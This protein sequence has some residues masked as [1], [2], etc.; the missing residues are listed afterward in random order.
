M[1]TLLKNPVV[2]RVRRLFILVTPNETSFE[3][4]EEVPN[5]VNEVSR[6]EDTVHKLGLTLSTESVN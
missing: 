6:C 4:L 5:Y 1:A 3:K 2:T